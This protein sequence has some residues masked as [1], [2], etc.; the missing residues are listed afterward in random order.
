MA[1]VADVVYNLIEPTV[2]SLGMKLWDVLFVKEGASYYL[3]VYIDKEGG[4]GI[5]DCVQ[6][7]RK[8]DPLIDKA[9]PIDKQYYL[10]VC[11]PGINRELRRDWHFIAADGKEVSV[12]LFS[13][14]SGKKEFCGTLKADSD[15]MLLLTDEGEIPLIR[16][17]IS[18]AY[19]KSEN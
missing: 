4:V 1:K 9:D 6:V 7:S 8:I 14:I 11:S 18:K 12:K 2:S 13:A 15:N 16:S 10:E 17:K 5:D 3:R 19:I